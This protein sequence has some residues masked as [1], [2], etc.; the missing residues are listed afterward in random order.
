M[1][2]RRPLFVVGIAIVLGAATFALAHPG[3]RD[4]QGG[5]N[6]RKA[7]NY[8]FHVGPLA[9]KTY[10]SKSAA[11]AA[12]SNPETPAPMP[13]AGQHINLGDST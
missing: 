9:G 2:F 6:D 12:L 13:E 3:G 8:H 10:P 4:A 11:T 7:G 1:S 5:H